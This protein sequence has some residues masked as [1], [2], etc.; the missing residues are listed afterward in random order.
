MLFLGDCQH[1]CTNVDHLVP[2]RFRQRLLL[3][4]SPSGVFH[5]V[6]PSQR[7][8]PSARQSQRDDLFLGVVFASQTA[9]MAG[10]VR[11]SGPIVLATTTRA[12]TCIVCSL[13]SSLCAPA[14]TAHARALSQH[15]L[16]TSSSLSLPVAH[17]PLLWPTV[18]R[19]A[20]ATPS[21]WD[22]RSLAC[23]Q[24]CLVSR[25][26]LVHWIAPRRAGGLIS[27]KTRSLNARFYVSNKFILNSSK[28]IFKLEQ[29][30]VEV[31]S[32]ERKVKRLKSETIFLVF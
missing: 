15:L 3:G 7:F 31:E 21:P 4:T 20:S 2:R 14:P 27:V 25:S 29:W 30:Q 23:G 8:I 10:P 12:L 16:A 6:A 19:S 24:S 5:F 22:C 18:Y 28:L 11:S 9:S 13:P 17:W 26:L 1:P 32:T